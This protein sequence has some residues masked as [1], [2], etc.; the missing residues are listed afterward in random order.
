[1]RN[2]PVH[3]YE[4]VFLRPHHFQASDRYWAEQVQTAVGWDNPY[5]NGL[6]EIA[7]SE[8][9]LANHQFELRKLQT[10]MRDGTL[11][12]LDA[13]Q[14]PDRLDIKEAISGIGKAVADLSEAFDESA[15]GS[16]AHRRPAK[17][18]SISRCLGKT[19]RLRT[20]CSRCRASRCV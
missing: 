16:F 2:L 3:W 17:T 5:D 11:V 7:F 12:D 4:G 6:H 18:E 20:T 19:R 8:E 13:G 15:S 10:R 14:T 9:A 1:M